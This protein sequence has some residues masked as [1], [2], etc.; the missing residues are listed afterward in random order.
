MTVSAFNHLWL[1]GLFGDLAM[2]E[3]FSPERQMAHMLAF[4][5]AWSRACGAAGLFDPTRAETAACAIESAQV[6]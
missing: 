1:S 4:E 6:N 2:G 5:A 3:V